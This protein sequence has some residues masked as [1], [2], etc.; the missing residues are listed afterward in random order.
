MLGADGTTLLTD[1]AEILARWAEHF[2]SLRHKQSDISDE[3]IEP[4]TEELDI[5]PNRAEVT[6]AIKQRSIGK[7]PGQDGIPQEVFNCGGAHMVTGL[8]KLFSA[9]WRKGQVLQDLNDASII[10]L[11]KRKGKQ[12]HCDN[13]R[14]IYLLSIA[15]TILA[16]V[17]LNRLTSVF[18]NRVYPESQCGFCSGRGMLT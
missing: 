15:G 9:F 13:H 11:Y 12:T 3:A 10:H 1:K 16:R 14:G 5:G 2:N 8:T 4:M 18:T 6:T 17:V 7:A